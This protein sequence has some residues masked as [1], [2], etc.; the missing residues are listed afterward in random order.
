MAKALVINQ[1][2]DAPF[3]MPGGLKLQRIKP[4][5]P[6][7][8]RIAHLPVPARLFIP[9]LGY[10]QQ[11]LAPSVQIGQ[12]V[13]KGD[14]LAP[15]IIATANGK[16]EQIAPHSIIHPSQGRGLCVTIATDHTEDGDTELEEKPVYKPL[17]E[18]TLERLER[19]AIVGLG[20]AGFGTSKKLGGHAV[21]TLIVNAVECEPFI[22]CD[23]S[24]LICHAEAVVQAIV[25]MI[26]FTQCRHCILAIENDKPEA[27]KAL[28][29][30]LPTAANAEASNFEILQ[31]SPVYPSGAERQLIHRL[32]GVKIPQTSRPS[33]QGIVCLNVA[34]VYAAWQAMLGFPLVS[35]IITIAGNNIKNPCNVWVR[36]GTRVADVLQLTG[37]LP[38]KY[39]QVRAGGPL[40]GFELGDY[41]APV[42]ATDNC[43][44]LKTEH[45][46]PQEA[47]PCIRCG[48]CSAACPAALLPQQ[49][50]WHANNDDIA[51][52]QRFGLEECI[53]C[54]CCDIVCP[55]AIRL[56]QT[57]RYAKSILKENDKQAETARQAKQRFHSR[58]QRLA[59]LKLADERKRQQAEKA[60]AEGNDA[61]T[62]ALKKARAR[63]RRARSGKP[64]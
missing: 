18:L 17:A 53:E 24:L 33:Q 20:G 23:E 46:M 60:L 64:T 3:L 6:T 26:D 29:M 27:I 37:N 48:A 44:T 12:V 11:E 43:I 42:C 22:S 25:T 14:S 58:E 59:R 54:G 10:Q 4:G 28:Q 30:A 49:L 47:Q 39:T 13:Q 63:K 16:V 8:G 36:I 55:S 34:T 15:G 21:D 35:R 38:E 50:H 40:S 51:G 61:I 5:L 31:L 2:R 56:T 41:A 7:A 45:S 52:A 19:C 9:L 32:T 62:E 1:C 57:F